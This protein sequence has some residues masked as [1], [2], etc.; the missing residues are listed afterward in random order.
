MNQIPLPHSHTKRFDQLDLEHF[1]K[2][3]YFILPSNPSEQR[4]KL[5]FWSDVRK[6]RSTQ[7]I[8]VVTIDSDSI[9]V[10][11]GEEPSK[12]VS[13]NDEDSVRELITKKEIVIDL[14][15]F[16]LHVW[17]VLIKAM[18][19]ENVDAKIIYVE[20]DSYKLHS[21]PSS[22]SLFDLSRE[23]SGISPLPGYAKLEEPDDESKAILVTLLGFEGNR[24]RTIAYQFDPPIK[25]IPVIGVPGFQLEFPTYTITCNQELLDEFNIFNDIWYARASCPFEALSALEDIRQDN[26]SSYMYIAPVGTKPHCL[27]SIIFALK[28]FS[29]TEILYDHPVRKENHTKGIGIAHIYDFKS[30]RT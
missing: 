26:P 20:P 1:P 23:F 30:F 5:S 10:K 17:A 24:P 21:N 14:T 18:W 13:L 2:D 22:S 6:H 12:V 3:T 16:S 4:A 11:I 9:N 19:Q 29:D 8:D 15:G 25:T 27:G 28:N 7:I